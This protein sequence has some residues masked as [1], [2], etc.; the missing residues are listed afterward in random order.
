[1]VVT[2]PMV[3]T[4][5]DESV[6]RMSIYKNVVSVNPW[7]SAMVSLV[8]KIPFNESTIVMVPALVDLVMDASEFGND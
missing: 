5:P 2:L 4:W 6:I 1:M 7:V 3:N 8:L